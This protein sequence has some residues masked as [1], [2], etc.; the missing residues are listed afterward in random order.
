M[1]RRPTP[2][3]PNY[4]V[5]CVCLGGGVV[6]TVF[7]FTTPVYISSCTGTCRHFGTI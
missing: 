4:W 7:I 2:F 3:S 5:D 6:N 1:Q